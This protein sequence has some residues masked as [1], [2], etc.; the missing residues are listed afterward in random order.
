MAIFKKKEKYKPIQ[1]LA[2]P[3]Q[4][5]N[6]YE[7]SLREKMLWFLI[8]F[9]ASGI[10]LF[11]FYNS[12]IV[13][14]SVGIVCGILFIPIRR[15]QVIE[16][17]KKNLTIQFRALLDALA[18]SV[19]A[20]KNMYDAFHG[21][22]DDLAV[23]FNQDADIVTEVKQISTGLYNNIQ[24]ENLLLNFA[25][26][27]GLEDVRNFANVFATCYK[28]GGN[29]NE[30]IKNTATIIGDKIEVQMEVET[31]VSGQK[32]QLSILMVMPVFFVL[33][34]RFLGGGLLDLDSLVGILSVTGAI[35]VF[36]L[37]YFIGKKIL[38]IKF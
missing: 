7:E 18:T 19:G 4:D 14:L 26:R 16:K 8:G 30:V 29:I 35:I 27:S 23:Q 32:G 34:L 9:A 21:A 25:E 38:D 1:G 37:A 20:G 13:S 36:I 28:K 31:M 24:I 22:A 17:R 3:A 2:G 33:V 11:A 5:Y 6:V 12:I 10:V 15:K